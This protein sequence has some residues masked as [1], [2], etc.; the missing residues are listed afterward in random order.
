[1][2]GSVHDAWVFANSGLFRKAEDGTLFPSIPAKYIAGVNIPLL[3]LADPAHPLL[4]WIQ[5]PY[6]DNGH[7]TDAQRHLNFKSSQ[8]RMAVEMDFGRLNRRWKSLE[9]RT[10]HTTTVICHVVVACVI[11]HNFCEC[12]GE[13]IPVEDSAT[14]IHQLHPDEIE[15][16]S[17]EETQ[18]MC[19]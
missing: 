6:S 16:E 5:K 17:I 11:L 8:S 7:L 4:N 2:P 14:E 18:T 15:P 9:Q 10:E 13:T 12:A 1:M 19:L 3:I